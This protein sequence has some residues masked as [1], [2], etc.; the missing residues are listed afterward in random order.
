MTPEPEVKTVD[1][2]DETEM[3]L[4]DIILPAQ[5]EASAR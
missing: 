1:C 3:K 5:I 2:T 4:E